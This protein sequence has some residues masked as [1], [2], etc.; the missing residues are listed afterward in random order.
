MEFQAYII[1]AV[2]L[3]SVIFLWACRRFFGPRKVNKKKGGLIWGMFLG[4][5]GIVLFAEGIAALLGAFGMCYFSTSTS[6]MCHPGGLPG[7]IF[8]DL[9]AGPGL[10]TGIIL[11]VQWVRYPF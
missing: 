6:L 9:L 4:G 3:I 8:R 2:F 11:T 5:L 7:Y 10:I 1:F